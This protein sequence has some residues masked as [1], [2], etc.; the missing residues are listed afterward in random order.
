[1]SLALRPPVAID[2]ELR[3]AQVWATVHIPLGEFQFRPSPIESWEFH[4]FNHTDKISDEEKAA[5]RAALP[6]LRTTLEVT[7]RLKK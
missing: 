2:C 1:M 5:L 3:G 4:F 6:A 7:Q